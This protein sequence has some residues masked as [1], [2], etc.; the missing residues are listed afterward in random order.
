M[1]LIL[2]LS[3]AVTTNGGGSDRIICGRGAMLPAALVLPG[4]AGEVWEKAG[5]D[6]GGNPQH[7]GAMRRAC[8]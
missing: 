2:G 7:E 5:G 8:C 3:R 6:G 4:C 1:R